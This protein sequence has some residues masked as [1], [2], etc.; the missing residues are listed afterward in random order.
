MRVEYKLLML[1]FKAL[2]NAR[3]VYLSDLL[4]VYQPHRSLLS[5]S[6]GLLLEV[7]SPKLTSYG[8][9]N[10]QV[11][12]SNWVAYSHKLPLKVRSCSTVSSFVCFKTLSFLCTTS[13]IDQQ[14]PTVHVCKSEYM[15]FARVF[16][17]CEW[18]LGTCL[19]GL[20]CVFV[21]VHRLYRLIV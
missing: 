4:H 3:P 19:G 10:L 17:G 11:C 1:V 8:D 6:D 14:L 18:Y 7:P 15:C 16:L 5:P 13:L 21:Y 2:H 9:K 12:K 20:V